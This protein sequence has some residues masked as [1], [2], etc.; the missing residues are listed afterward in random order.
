MVETRPLVMVLLGHESEKEES[1]RELDDVVF[2]PSKSIDLDS[3]DSRTRMAIFSWL[4]MLWLAI[5]NKAL[6]GASEEEMRLVLETFSQFKT[7]SGASCLHPLDL[8]R[9]LELDICKN[10]LMM[11]YSRIGKLLALASG[12]AGTGLDAD[13]T[14]LL[15]L[16]CAG[17][18]S[19]QGKVTIPSVWAQVRRESERLARQ[20]LSSPGS[21]SVNREDVEMVMGRRIAAMIGDVIQFVV[22]DGRKGKLSDWQAGK[23]WE[24]LMDLWVGLCRAV[25]R[26]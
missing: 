25:S 16:V 5:T 15:L 7:R 11:L 8:T 20:A 10:Y 12:I 24:G 26:G 21:N 17:S 22:T 19:P 4:S 18:A 2:L 23:E 14:H 3:L 1:R 13:T 6:H 9:G